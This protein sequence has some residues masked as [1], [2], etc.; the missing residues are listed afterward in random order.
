MAIMRVATIQERSG[1]AP[2]PLVRRKRLLR[3]MS[4]AQ[5]AWVSIGISLYGI[6]RNRPLVLPLFS[7][8]LI[9]FATRAISLIAS[10]I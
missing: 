4:G 1:F 8:A 6:A 2:L 5:K 10:A 3:G 9:Y 7:I